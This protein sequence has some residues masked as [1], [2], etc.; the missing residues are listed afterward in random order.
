ME[1]VLITGANRGIGLEMVRRH[2]E[3]GDEVIAVCR[4]VSDELRKT[5]AQIIDGLDMADGAAIDALKKRFAVL[6]IDRLIANAGIRGLEGYD[7]LDF[8]SIRYQY[9]VNA[10]GPLRLVRA[11]DTAL[12]DGAKVVLISTLVASLGDNGSGGEFGYRMSK[13]A[14]NM[15]GVNLSHA[16]KSRN[17]T[18]L[19]L[20][21]GWVQTELGGEGALVEVGESAKKLISTADQLGLEQTGTFWD[22]IEGNKLPW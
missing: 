6:S 19:L 16:L 14:L 13:A 3:R 18:V 5:G 21:P 9:E 20:H 11:L 4:Q 2:T 10:M 22:V 17:I 7:D 8:D 12:A 15:V 1:T